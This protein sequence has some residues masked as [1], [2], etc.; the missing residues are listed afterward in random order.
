[1]TPQQTQTAF[2]ASLNDFCRKYL[3]TG[4]GPSP[5]RQAFIADI[6]A[7]RARVFEQLMLFDKVNFKVYGEN[8]LVP[9]LIETF[10]LPAFEALIEQGAFRFTLWTH[11]IVYMKSEVPGID[12]LGHLTQ[13]SPA[14]SDPEKSVEL[15]FNW[16]RNK[17]EPRKLRSLTKKLIN[18]YEV[19]DKDLAPDAVAQTYSAYKSGKLK[20]IGF[21]QPDKELRSLNLEE[22][23]LLCKYSGEVLNYSHLLRKGMT[24]YS[25]FSYF[26]LLSQTAGKLKQS[27]APG[28]F[29]TLV[30]LEGFPDLAAMFPQEPKTFHQLPKL[31]MKKNTVKFRRWLASERFDESGAS[32]T[33]EYLDAISDPKGFFE[34][35][36]GK[37]VKAVALTSVGSGIGALAGGAEGAVTGALVAKA[38]EPLGHFGLDLLDEFVVNGLTKGWSPRL[39]FDDARKLNGKGK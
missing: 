22:R 15:G 27:G 11:D 30:E 5:T 7:E 24:S 39:F 36:K 32:V 34:T 3:V 16:Y 1:M 6:A 23:A 26:T 37:V 35:P 9:V 28:N 10:G 33:R 38:L 21:E 4:Q 13:N 31:R 20:Q 19:P 29:S 25:S 14:H 2:S 17:L 18:L 12:P 8:I